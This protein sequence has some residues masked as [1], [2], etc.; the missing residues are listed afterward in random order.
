MSNVTTDE[1][2]KQLA[3]NTEQ[4]DDEVQTTDTVASTNSSDV[5]EH[6]STAANEPI[7]H[8]DEQT[9]SGEVSGA[10]ANAEAEAEAELESLRERAAAGQHKRVGRHEPEAEDWEIMRRMV[11]LDKTLTSPGRLAVLAALWRAGD[12]DYVYLQ[13][14]AGSSQGNLATHCRKL[15]D[16]GLIES[17]KTFIHRRANTRLFITDAGRDAISGYVEGMRSLMERVQSWQPAIDD[18][19]EFYEEGENEE[20]ENDQPTPNPE[21]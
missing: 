17:R 7:E 16:A 18:Y 5:D 6:R 2:I 21:A 9:G 10:E 14:L 3:R 12:L 13:N 4:R 8:S 1:K 19:H 15:E 11:T 20:A